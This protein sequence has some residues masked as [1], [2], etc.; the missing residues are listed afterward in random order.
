MKALLLS[1]STMPGESYLG[2]CKELIAKFFAQEGIQEIV[3]VPYAGV[4][5]DIRGIEES[6]DVYTEKVSAV[7]REFTL[8]IIPLHRDKHPK[9]LIISARGILVGGGNTFYLVYKLHELGL[10]DVIARRVKKDGVLYAGW[11]AGANIAAPGL[12]TT[13]DMPIVQPE[14][15]TT[16]N[17]IPF[18]INPHYT[19]FHHPQHGGE[20][21]RQRLAEFLQVNRHLKVV[22]LPEGTYLSIDNGQIIFYGSQSAL[23]FEFGKEPVPI[24]NAVDLNQFV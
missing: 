21:R 9:E 11:S 5:L 15:F 23:W 12:Y 7:L 10:M 13:N 19:D 2:W 16:L 20:T 22:G 17:L 3:F 24:E 8:D 1:N 6:Y 14:S 4:N 18:Q